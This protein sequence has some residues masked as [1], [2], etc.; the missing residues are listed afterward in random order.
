M[1]DVR[2]NLGVVPHP[3]RGTI[4]V[5]LKDFVH[6]VYPQPFAPNPL[7]QELGA[8]L[9]KAFREFAINFYRP[10]T[11]TNLNEWEILQALKRRCPHEA[12]GEYDRAIH[13]AR[14]IYNE[15]K[16]AYRQG[17]IHGVPPCGD[18]NIKISNGIFLKGK[19]SLLAENT[20]ELYVLKTFS[21]H[22]PLKQEM[23][24]VF[25]QVIGLSLLYPPPWRL[26][27]CGFSG[28]GQLQ[29]KIVEPSPEDREKFVKELYLYVKKR[30]R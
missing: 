21:L 6:D 2:K 11:K 22:F 20:G 30:K 1:S 19:A 24:D 15:F 18:R 3:R 13:R 25:Y 27:L 29:A 26:W 17:L 5:N 12:E 16:R 4:I 10:T 23:P 8:Q 28:T 7:N 14:L 9:H